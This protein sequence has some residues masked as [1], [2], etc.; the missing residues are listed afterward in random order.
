[1]FLFS[2]LFGLATDPPTI[3][4]GLLLLGWL[5]A[6]TRRWR[7][8]GLRILGGTLCVLV[9]LAVVPVD[10]R[11][12][13]WLEDRF[14]PPSP[15]PEHVDG[16][17]VLGGAISMEVSAARGQVSVGSAITRL[18][19]LVPLARRYPEARLVFTA[20]S[21][22]PFDQRLKEATYARQFYDDIG[23]DSSRIVFEDQSRNTHENATLTKALIQPKP[24]ETWLLITSANHMPR[25]VGCFRAA[26]WPVLAYPVDYSTDG[27]AGPWWRQ[28]R[29]SAN[30]GFS[31]LTTLLHEGLGL[32]SYRLLGWTDAIFPQP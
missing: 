7:R 13:G 25:A 11:A 32:V 3:I 27:N 18:T 10:R 4:L 21:G 16:I 31:G 23:F 9:V 20:G 14:P 30:K 5:L 17:I 1:M 29:F 2:K 19:S 15:M 22:N 26:G 8:R 6:L 28:L 12:F 24:G